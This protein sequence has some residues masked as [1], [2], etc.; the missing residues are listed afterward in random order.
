[1]A[2]AAGGG[3]AAPGRPRC[4]ARGLLPFRWLGGR[5]EEAFVPAAPVL[6][7]ATPGVLYPLAWSRRA[8]AAAP[9]WWSQ[10]ECLLEAAPEVVLRIELR[11]VQVVARALAR[12]GARGLEPADALERGAERI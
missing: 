9:P 5:D 4:E 7:A 1:M 6:G 12:P 10:T 8:D 2:A 3:A 11:F